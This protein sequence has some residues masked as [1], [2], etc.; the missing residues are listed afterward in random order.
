MNERLV[1]VS[2]NRVIVF[3]F[4]K[5][6]SLLQSQ[7]ENYF[8]NKFKMFCQKYIFKIK[9]FIHFWIFTFNTYHNRLN[10]FNLTKTNK[11]L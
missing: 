1:L 5:F 10:N 2:A 9:C 8:P 4:I 3:L 11:I 6:L 7:C